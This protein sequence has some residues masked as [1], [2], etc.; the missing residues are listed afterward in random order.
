MD[1]LNAPGALAAFVEC[2]LGDI[3][4]MKFGASEREEEGES[5]PV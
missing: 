1:L 3:W 4:H 5:S 2:T